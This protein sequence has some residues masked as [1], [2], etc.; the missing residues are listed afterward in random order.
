MIRRTPKLLRKATTG[1]KT[2]AK[3]QDAQDRLNRRDVNWYRI[4][5]TAN[6]DIFD[7]PERL[8][9]LNKHPLSPTWPFALHYYFL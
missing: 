2:L 3:A 6:R 5:S 8:G 4:L 9:L 1:F 7:A